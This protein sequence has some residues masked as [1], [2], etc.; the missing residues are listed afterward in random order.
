[1]FFVSIHAIAK[2]E[3]FKTLK[4]NL[5]LKYTSQCIAWSNVVREMRLKSMVC[6]IK[7]EIKRPLQCHVVV[8]ATQNFSFLLLLFGHIQT[9][10]SIAAMIKESTWTVRANVQIA[11]KDSFISNRP[12]NSFSSG[13]DVGH[14]CTW[15]ITWL[16]ALSSMQQLS[17]LSQCP[18]PIHLSSNSH[19]HCPFSF[20]RDLF[21]TW[22]P[23]Y[24]YWFVSNS[25]LER[26]LLQ[27]DLWSGLQQ[28][29]SLPNMLYI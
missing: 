24:D 3:N 8:V 4:N 18:F 15:T 12:C 16:R 19:Q 2:I 26:N 21:R 22:S 10:T 6:G 5:N 23:A 13:H 29:L 28:L 17:S 11:K 14:V 27:Q 1:M 7:S 25:T 9:H 20:K